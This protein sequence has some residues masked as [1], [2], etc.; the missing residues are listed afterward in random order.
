MYVSPIFVDLK[1][2]TDFRG[3][4]FIFRER[5]V[6]S[7]RSKLGVVGLDESHRLRVFFLIPPQN[8]TLEYLLGRYTPRA[9]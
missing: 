5:D 4:R 9:F 8:L 1:M 6:L 3:F 2:I 7:R